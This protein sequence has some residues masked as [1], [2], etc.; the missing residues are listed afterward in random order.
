MSNIIYSLSQIDEAT[1]FLKEQSKSK[2]L[3]FYGD[4]GAGKTTLIKAFLR[5]LGAAETGSSPTFGLV[6]EYYTHEN[7][8][9]AYHLDC[10]RLEGTEEALDMGIE[11]YL[12][13]DC[14]VFLEWPQRIAALLPDTRTEIHLE[15]M[16]P[17][18]RKLTVQNI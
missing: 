9:L 4:L 8:L 13:A 5:K 16:D 15:S 7:K 17:E 1:S 2:K 3:C 14:Y 10:Y 12:D 11:E 18:R 6:H